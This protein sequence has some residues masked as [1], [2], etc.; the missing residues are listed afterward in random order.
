ML[1]VAGALSVASFT[2]AAQAAPDEEDIFARI[3][4]SESP[5]YYPSLMLRYRTGDTTL[6]T[7]DYR[8]LYYG[9]AYSDDYRPQATIEAEDKLLTVFDSMKDREPTVGD[10]EDIV[11]YAGQV[12]ERDPFSPGNLNFLVYAYGAL[13]DTENERVNY[14][15]LTKVL[16]AIESSGSGTRENA[17]WHII[18]FQHA[19]DFLA[20]RGLYVANRLVV[21]R[22]VEYITVTDEG[23]KRR[24]DGYYFD[25]SRIYRNGY[26]PEP[27]PDR[28]WTINNQSVGKR[29]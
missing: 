5:Y 11:L 23:G 17:P 4:D 7:D 20:A 12:M 6:T 24:S 14:D 13:G 25:Y 3:V 26:D 8:Y 18:R 16:A 19:A 9:Y 10:M 27:Q 21:S 29:N 28:G 15:R 1:A 2:A 22:S